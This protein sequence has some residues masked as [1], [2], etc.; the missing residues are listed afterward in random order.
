VIFEDGFFEEEELRDFLLGL[1]IYITPY[2]NEGQITSGTISY[3]LGA[4]AC[5]V[6]TPFWH[7]K[8]LL[9][10]GRGVTFGFGD[11][12]DLSV[13]INTLLNNPQQIKTI[14]AKAFEYGKKMYW[15]RIGQHYRK[16]LDKILS[17]PLLQ[18]DTYRYKRTSTLPQFSMEHIKRLTDDTG[19]VEHASYSIPD[20]K[21]GYCLDDN[22]RALLLVL[23]AWE[24]GA[25]K[26]SM[27]LAS[28]Y[29][30]Y[31]KLMQKTD[32][33]FHNDMSFDKRFLDDTGSEDSFGRTIWAIGYL[34]RLAPNDSHF[35]FAKDVF[36]KAFPHFEQLTSIRAIANVIIGIS[37]FLKRYPDNERMMHV[38]NNMTQRLIQ[39][40][41]DESDDNWQWFE[42]V[43]CYDNAIL[44]LALWHTYG[45]T[46]NKKVYEVAKNTTTFLTQETNV[47]GH[48]SL[49]GNGW[50]HKGEARPAQGQQPINCMAMVMMYHKAWQVTRNN[51][52][53]EKML[54]AFTWFMGN[55]DIGVPLYDEE[56]A[57]CCDGLELHGVNRNQG[58]ESTISYQLSYLSIYAAEQEMAAMMPQQIT[59]SKTSSLAIIPMMGEKQVALAK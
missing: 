10:E 19:I 34:I 26:E 15:G 18:E 29:L 42:P 16:L 30:R 5:I 25:D 22:A 40:Y 35:Q 3:A 54:T 36:F 21:E 57:G 49:V 43:L 45:I 50:Y 11:S 13:K 28:T 59:A 4:G 20:Y 6:S 38:L 7:A 32:G 1:D 23:M 24:T 27:P 58:A 17:Q 52:Y 46:K 44:P 39:Q 55:N 47:N 12:D 8:E 48:V 9:A 41:H 37:H 2:L 51:S 33:K 53:H 31:I 14:K 56:T